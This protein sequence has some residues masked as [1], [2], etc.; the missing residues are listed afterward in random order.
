MGKVNLNY[1]IKPLSITKSFLKL[2]L[3]EGKL[4][5]S[6]KKDCLEWNL[7][8]NDFKVLAVFRNNHLLT[9]IPF[10]LFKENFTV[11]ELFKIAQDIFPFHATSLLDSGALTIA[12][13]KSQIISGRI[14]IHLPFLCPEFPIICKL[15]HP[16]L[17][18]GSFHKE[19]FLA[20]RVWLAR[21]LK[22]WQDFQFSFF[23]FDYN[24]DRSIVAF[25]LKQA[26]KRFK[27]SKIEVFNRK[28]EFQ[29][30]DQRFHVA[31][32]RD[33]TNIVAVWFLRKDQQ[34]NLF[35]LLSTFND[36]FS[37]YAPGNALTYHLLCYIKESN[38]AS[39]IYWG[40]IFHRATP[41]YKLKW[42]DQ[43]TTTY[44]YHV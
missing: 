3:K 23:E 32:L 25:Y 43:F 29:K 18:M 36:E 35:L 13:K 27:F 22:K 5:V 28:A 21:Q 11:H 39:R 6:L 2:C 12:L 16:F 30:M 31:V 20:D 44:L 42:C 9:V 26:V 8:H 38:L 34:R 14:L 1:N 17:D 33:N 24:R 40:P 15:T 41:S 7:Y 19:A 37:N 10:K 4:R